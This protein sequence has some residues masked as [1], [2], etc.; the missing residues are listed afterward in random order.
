SAL[1]GQPPNNQNDWYI[2]RGFARWLSIPD[3][4]LDPSHGFPLP[5]QR[6]PNDHYTSRGPGMIASLSVAMA[7]VILITGARLYLRY[8]RRDLKVGIDDFVIVPAA[9]TAVAYF[10]L[11]IG[12]VVYGG[13]GKHIYDMTY[14]EV[15]WF[16]ELGFIGII[17]FFL[18]VGLIK[19]SIIFF[20]RRLTGLTSRRWMLAHYGFLSLVVIYMIF[21]LFMEL[22]QC[23]G[24][25]ELKF[26]LIARGSHPEASKCLDGNKLGYSLSIVH[27]TMDFALLTVPLIILYQMQMSTRKKIKLGFLFSIGALSCIG[28]V[29]RQVVQTR[30][31]DEI[32]FPWSYRE[33]LSWIIVDI[34]FGMVAASLPVLNA[35]LPKSWR[36]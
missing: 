20:N 27:S 19:I 6:P 36:A 23:T 5:L 34:F 18:G 21:A 11:A 28:S 32:D 7:L 16:Y 17:V 24:P 4:V 8:S 1:F 3:E 10:A 31:I 13:A 33:E 35:A 12:M 2:I 29:M 9:L 15:D 26:S 30:I 22:F 14:E 25:A